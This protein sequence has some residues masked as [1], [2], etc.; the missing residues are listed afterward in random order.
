[1]SAP[2]MLPAVLIIGGAAYVLA[3]QA[4]VAPLP[5]GG[6]GG[7]SGQAPPYDPWGL[8]LQAPDPG[9]S[10][11][12]DALL[13]AGYAKFQAMSDGEKVSAAQELNSTLNLQPPLT[14]RESWEAVASAAGGA[15]ASAACNAIPGVGMAAGP[16][17]AIAGSYLGV[18]LEDWM[19]SSLG[20]VQ[21]WISQNVPGV[22]GNVVDDVKGWLTGLF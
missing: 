21:T 15:A 16:L 22:V 3:D 4:P 6:I 10:S 18:K 8:S 20:D 7:V 14:G 5:V 2:A 17:C 1:M 12:I 9:S 13:A 11:K 19:Q